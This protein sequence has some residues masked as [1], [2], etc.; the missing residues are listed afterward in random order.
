MSAGTEASLEFD[1]L[2]DLVLRACVSAGDLAS[3]PA[4]TRPRFRRMHLDGSRLVV[5]VV[6]LLGLVGCSAGGLSAESP[7]ASMSAPSMAPPQQ[8]CTG[9]QVPS[10][11]EQRPLT[12]ADGSGINTVWLG[13]GSTAALLLHQTDGN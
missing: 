4:I 2:S 3:V 9:V 11:V 8:Y 5:L 6:V 10:G 13:S 1:Y 12:A 7:S